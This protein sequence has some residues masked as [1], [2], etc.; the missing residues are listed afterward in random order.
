M[1]T[2]QRPG[3]GPGEETTPRR[4]LLHEGELRASGSV[5]CV[6][7]RDLSR[8]GLALPVV[9]FGMWRDPEPSKDVRDALG[10]LRGVSWEVSRAARHGAVLR[11]SR[12]G[13][14]N[15]LYIGFSQ[16]VLLASR[17]N[18]PCWCETQPLGAQPERGSGFM[19]IRKAF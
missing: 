14:A 2:C 16:V 4:D 5:S 12:T 15:F 19:E 11:G 9:D 10:G 13:S 17:E 1:L 8:G 6:L 7:D 3:G 18:C